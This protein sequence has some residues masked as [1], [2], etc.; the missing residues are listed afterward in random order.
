MQRMG[1]LE[2]YPSWG[3]G[4]AE[5]ASPPPPNPHF[6][7]MERMENIVGG[8]EL[9]GTVH[10][11]LS[12]FLNCCKEKGKGG[13]EKERNLLSPPGARIVAY[14][15]NLPAYLPACLLLGA[16]GRRRRRRSHGMIMSFI[17]FLGEDYKKNPPTHLHTHTHTKKQQKDLSY[18]QNYYLLLTTISNL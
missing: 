10:S 15:F 11:I 5:R 7:L 12:N 16:G 13:G 9:D 1:E 14:L 2:G 18:S 3:P 8:G 4:A 6:F 17:G